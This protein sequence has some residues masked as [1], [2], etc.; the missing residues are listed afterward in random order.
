MTFNTAFESI[1]DNAIAEFA[2]P[3]GHTMTTFDLMQMIKE[4]STEI[5][6]MSLRSLSGNFDI[7]GHEWEMVKVPYAR[8]L[9]IEDNQG[10]TIIGAD[11]YS[12]NIEDNEWTSGYFGQVAKAYFDDNLGGHSSFDW[13]GRLNVDDQTF[14]SGYVSELGEV[15]EITDSAGYTLTVND[16]NF[17]EVTVVDG[18]D[19]RVNVYSFLGGEF[20]AEDVSGL[21]V[22]LGN[23][24]RSE[25]RIDD[26]DAVNITA[27]GDMMEVDVN[28]SQVES[29]RLYGDDTELSVHGSTV[30][31]LNMDED[32]YG[33]FHN[34][35][36][37]GKIGSGTD[38]RAIDART[39]LDLAGD[40]AVTIDGGQALLDASN[41]RTDT[42]IFKNKA[43]VDVELD[44]FDLI[45]F[46]G[47]T[48]WR[49][50][51][52]NADPGVL[53]TFDFAGVE[54]GTYIEEDFGWMKG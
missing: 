12:V 1:E 18:T 41:G 44:P 16:G 31:G 39:I 3:L 19:V 24:D 53:D 15:A 8:F 49:A 32:G 20:E 36:V 14:G 26:S 48:T 28:A 29:L 54:I 43:K 52:L 6:Y 17:T 51:E 45:S 38:V 46:G 34:S 9:D 21:D 7:D 5:N 10:T 13:L 22:Y 42:L 25:I 11:V 40:N 30:K 35:S 37:T 33:H 4:L 27:V 50:D 23:A 47:A 2:G